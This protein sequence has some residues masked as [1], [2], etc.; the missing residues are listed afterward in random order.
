LTGMLTSPKE[1]APFQML[2]MSQSSSPPTG[3]V[4]RGQVTWGLSGAFAA[5]LAYGVATVLQATGARQTSRS[6]A[7]DAHLLWQL[8]HSMPYVAGLL[9]DGVA[10]A[11][12]LAA[13]RTEPLFT[14]QAIVASSL[15]VTA[16]LAVAVLGA[17]PSIIE[18]AALVF[19]TSGLVLLALSATSQKPAHIDYGG[20]AGLL[21]GVVVVGGA[22]ALIARRTGERAGRRRD[23]WALGCLAGLMYGAG[24]IGARVLANPTSIGSLLVDPALWAML[25]AG[26]LLATWHGHLGDIG[27]RRHRD[28]GSGSAR[29]HLPR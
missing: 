24:A 28:T 2:R 16:L 19:V 3:P 11:L 22:A 27:R 8:V 18:W 17:R 9:L 15:A 23:T 25:F 7:P 4:Y 6:A 26:I 21:A 20:R 14:V 5:A 1:I 29:H 12:S 13:L 10:F